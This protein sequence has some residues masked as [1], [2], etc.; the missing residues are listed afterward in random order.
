MATHYRRVADFLHQA[1]AN[2][3]IQETARLKPRHDRP[4]P[5]VPGGSEL[6][7]DVIAER[8][9]LPGMPAKAR[10]ALADIRTMSERDAYA[11]NIENFIGTA[12]VPVGL[13]GP[14]RI[15]G[16]HAQG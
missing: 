8:W 11:R 6:T 1:F 13:A 9:S 7:E 16:A 3:D 10:E 14:L 5:R 12:K 2:R 4:G 15:N